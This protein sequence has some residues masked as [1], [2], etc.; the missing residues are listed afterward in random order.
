MQVTDIRGRARAVA[1]PNWFHAVRSDH[2]KERVEN[3]LYRGQE[4]S[5]MRETQAQIGNSGKNGPSMQDT[6]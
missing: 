2:I 3:S 6:R 4:K 5:T 1:P